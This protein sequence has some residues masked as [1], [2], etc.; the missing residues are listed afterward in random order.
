MRDQAGTVVNS[1][2]FVHFTKGS[3]FYVTNGRR[4][5][6]MTA[7][8]PAYALDW[9]K[10]IQASILLLKQTPLFHYYQVSAICNRILIVLSK[11]KEWPIRLEIEVSQGRSFFWMVSL[12]GPD[13][14]LSVICLST[15]TAKEIK[16]KSQEHLIEHGVDF[17]LEGALLKV[18]NVDYFV[19]E[20]NIPLYL[21]ICPRLP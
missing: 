11:E 2:F 14:K 15:M 5:Y 20:E 4:Y 12:Y 3:V 1:F 8:S 19:K 18:I 6:E 17:S 9:V 13:K 16:Q 10:H 7:K 21:F